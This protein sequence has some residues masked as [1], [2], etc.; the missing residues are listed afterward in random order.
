MKILRPPDGSNRTRMLA[1]M[2]C[3]SSTI[4]TYQILLVVPRG[5]AKA[6]IVDEAH[7]DAAAPSY[8]HYIFTSTR[9]LGNSYGAPCG[10]GE[11][12][13]TS[14]NNKITERTGPRW[15]PAMDI[16]CLGCMMYEFATGHCLYKPEVADDLPYNIIHLAQMTQR[17]SGQD[18]DDLALEQ[19]EIREERR[20]LNRKEMYRN[21]FNFIQLLGNN[22]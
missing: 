7:R 11:T 12:A 14:Q 18:Y 19:Y 10:Y 8:H 3:I 6:T 5:R 13:S 16:W 2:Q 20:N 21:I 1:L 15:G 9:A 4:A 17:T 22:P